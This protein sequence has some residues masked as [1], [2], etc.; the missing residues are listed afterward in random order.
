MENDKDEKQ[1]TVEQVQ[2]LLR[3]LDEACTAHSE[4]QYINN[5]NI[6]TSLVPYEQAF[7]EARSKFVDYAFK[8][9]IDPY[10]YTFSWVI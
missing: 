6:I 8:L 10:N 5:S 4:Y 3:L 9:G 1:I 2:E 7:N